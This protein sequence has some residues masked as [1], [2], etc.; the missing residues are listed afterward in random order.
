MILL[1]I[2]QSQPITGR[3]IVTG[4]AEQRFCGWMELIAAVTAAGPPPAGFDT[5]GD[6]SPQA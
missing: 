1:T 3:L 6:R 2:E 4:R 5:P